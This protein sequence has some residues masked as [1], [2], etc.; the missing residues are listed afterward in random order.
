M[1]NCFEHVKAE[2][3][4]TED[5]GG[6]PI[7]PGFGKTCAHSEFSP[8]VKMYHGEAQRDQ[9]EERLAEPGYQ[10]RRAPDGQHHAKMIEGFAQ[11]DVR[12]LARAGMARGSPE[13]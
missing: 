9:R 11:I 7:S 13:I 12:F 10:E 5:R 1:E 2:H 6:I 3:H 4:E 8:E